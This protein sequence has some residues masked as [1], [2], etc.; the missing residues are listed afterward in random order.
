MEKFRFWLSPLVSRAVPGKPSAGSKLSSGG[1]NS[2]FCCSNW[3]MPKL[4]RNISS[5]FSLVW[6]TRLALAEAITRQTV[7]DVSGQGR[8]LQ[9][10]VGAADEGVD[11]EGAVGPP[12]QIEEAGGER[13]GHVVGHAGVVV[14]VDATLGHRADDV[15]G[16]PHPQPRP[17]VGVDRQPPG[18]LLVAGAEH[19]AGVVALVERG[20]I[21]DVLVPPARLMM[22]SLAK[23]VRPDSCSSWSKVRPCW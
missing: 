14:V 6:S 13:Q 12:G 9:G 1:K 20:V 23:G 15:G 10:V 21:G 11:G 16:E 19:D 18:L 3:S 2:L 7:L 5:C 4:V 17:Q 8:G 22:V